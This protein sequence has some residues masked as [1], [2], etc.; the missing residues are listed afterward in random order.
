MGLQFFPFYHLMMMMIV[1][2]LFLC[3][4]WFFVLFQFVLDH[5]MMMMVNL[6]NLG[7]YLLLRQL[8]LDRLEVYHQAL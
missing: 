5:L 6:L 7:L 1:N 4:F 8:Y 2:L 3:F